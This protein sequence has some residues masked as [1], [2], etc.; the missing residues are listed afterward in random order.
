M[1]KELQFSEV[2]SLS[3]FKNTKGKNESESEAENAITKKNILYVYPWWYNM[4]W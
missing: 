2:I 3:G 4:H 1:R